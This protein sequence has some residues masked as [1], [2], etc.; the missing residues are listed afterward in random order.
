MHR[1]V[2]VHA[3]GFVSFAL[4]QDVSAWRNVSRLMPDADTRVQHLQ[5]ARRIL[6]AGAPQFLGAVAASGHRQTFTA[7]GGNEAACITQ[8][9]RVPRLDRRRG[10]RCGA[11]CNVVSRNRHRARRASRRG[12][13]DGRDHERGKCRY[14]PVH[15][16]ASWSAHGSIVPICATFGNAGARH[17]SARHWRPAI[18]TMQLAHVRYAGCLPRA[19]PCIPSAFTWTRHL[20]LAWNYR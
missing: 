14:E 13:H 8:A 16:Q 19:E 3:K 20:P 10:C 11:E 12:S 5:P 9:S 4:E 18:L 6:R 2:W 1:Q 7:L 15:W 17:C